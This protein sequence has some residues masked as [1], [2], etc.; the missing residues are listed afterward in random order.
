MTYPII[1]IDEDVYTQLEQLGTKK[2][3]WYL[4]AK[5]HKYLF[6]EGRPGTGENWA[7]KVCCEIC[8]LI[9]LPHANYDLA[10]FQESKGVITPTFVP[11]DGRLV[12]GNE[13]LAE[14]HSDYKKAVFYRSQQHTLS[15][16]IA[17]I[18]K[19]GAKFPIGWS[20]PESTINTVG[21]FVGYLLLDALV[22]NQDRH[23]ENWGMIR[24]IEHGVC[25]APTY[26]HASSL[27]RNE[28][29]KNRLRRLHTKDKG[30]SV[31]S[32]AQ[33]AISGLYESKNDKK[34]MSTLGAFIKSANINRQ[35]GR[36]WLEKLG[37]INNSSF[38]DILNLIPDGEITEPGRDFAFKMLEVNKENLLNT[39]L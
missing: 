6:K 24:S 29:D 19:T 37:E 31:E 34:P 14:M 38:M 7:E 27:G 10:T 4:D 13:L 39:R 1:A 30:Q 11:D 36:Y 17:A 28:L 2:K 3:F 12:H 21:I 16:A 18:K 22:G 15:R 32:Y 9:G 35:G 8:N 26:D 25:L 20:F 5:K 33:R 23:H